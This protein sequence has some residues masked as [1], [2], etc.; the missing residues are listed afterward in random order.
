MPSHIIMTSKFY[1]DLANM[2]N[3][4]YQIDMSDDLL[5]KKRLM[6]LLVIVT[7]VSENVNKEGYEIVGRAD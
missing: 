4:R 6:G 7:P 5:V 2:L 3:D 1:F